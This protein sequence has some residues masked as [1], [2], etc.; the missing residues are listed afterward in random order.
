MCVDVGFWIG[1]GRWRWRWR[2][3]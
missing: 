2:V 1:F 3:W